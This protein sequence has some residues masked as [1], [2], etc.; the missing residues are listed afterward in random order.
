MN[1]LRI[2][3]KG[4]SPI[5]ATLLLVSFVVA[6][7]V[8]IINWSLTNNDI[9]SEEEAICGGRGIIDV[10]SF[11]NSK[12]VCYT[13][14]NAA[15]KVRIALENKGDNPITRV[16]VTIFGLKELKKQD[17]NINLAPG[18]I[19]RDDITYD[20]QKYGNIEG[21]VISPYVTNEK[22]ALSLPRE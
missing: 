22:E 15:G 20:F 7:S 2:R 10:V 13:G 5:I 21:V 6:I 9:S 3:K 16:S 12:D 17:L 18:D 14:I 1:M 11:S 19:L 8:L 4:V